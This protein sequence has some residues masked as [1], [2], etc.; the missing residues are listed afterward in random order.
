MIKLGFLIKFFVPTIWFQISWWNKILLL[1]LLFPVQKNSP[2]HLWAL[3]YCLWEAVGHTWDGPEL[4]SPP[5]EL[6]GQWR[7]VSTQPQ[8]GQ[9]SPGSGYWS[10]LCSCMS[11][12]TPNSPSAPRFHFIP[13]L[14]F[15]GSY[16]WITTGISA[17]ELWLLTHSLSPFLYSHLCCRLHLVAAPITDPTNPGLHFCQAPLGQNQLSLSSFL[18]RCN[19]DTVLLPLNSNSSS[20]SWTDSLVN[21]I[22]KGPCSFWH[23]SNIVT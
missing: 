21:W 11:A 22:W 23:S 16:I 14:W 6:A 13:G 15:A 2:I 10:P 19:L 20:Q 9:V 7:V 5:T 4:E 17:C 1:F 18:L 12:Q 3:S 8:E